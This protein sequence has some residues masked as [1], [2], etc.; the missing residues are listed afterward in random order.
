MRKKRLNKK[1][2]IVFRKILRKLF[3]PLNSEE[4]RITLNDIQSQAYV[5]VKKMIQHKDSILTYAPESQ[6]YLVQLDEYCAKINFETLTI[7]NG[8]FSYYILMPR[9]YNIKLVKCFNNT[10]EKR[11]KD[12]DNKFNQ[13]ALKHLEEIYSKIT[14]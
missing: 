8:K 5:N 9:Y 13:N 2:R 11:F 4:Y 1:L 12:F 3:K 6:S 7:K 14:T 10:C